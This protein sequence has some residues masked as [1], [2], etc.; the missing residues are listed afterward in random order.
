MSILGIFVGDIC[1]FGKLPLRA[2][3]QFTEKSTRI[4]PETIFQKN[5]EDHA[6]EITK[7]GDEWEQGPAGRGCLNPEL[8]VKVITLPI[9]AD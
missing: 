3:F 8:T 2:V 9:E 1:P 5:A 7:S 6:W 4:N